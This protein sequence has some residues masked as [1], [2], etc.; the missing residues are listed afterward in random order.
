MCATVK[1]VLDVS[2]TSSASFGYSRNVSKWKVDG[3]DRLYIAKAGSLGPLKCDDEV[4]YRRRVTVKQASA[5]V[6]CGQP[7]RV[8]RAAIGC[9]SAQYVWSEP[10]LRKARGVDARGLH[11]FTLV[12]VTKR[13]GDLQHHLL[14]RYVS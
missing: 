9:R 6:I 5:A 14:Q 8:H 1:F 13:D 10:C 3:Q 7:A 11:Y 2:P 12:V 4:L